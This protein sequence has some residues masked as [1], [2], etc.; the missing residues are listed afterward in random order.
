[1]NNQSS[2]TICFIG[3]GAGARK[4]VYATRGSQCRSRNLNNDARMRILVVGLSVSRMRIPPRPSFLV[5]DA[6][7]SHMPHTYR[8]CACSRHSGRPSTSQRR[9]NTCWRYCPL[10]GGTSRSSDCDCVVGYQCN[11]RGGSWMKL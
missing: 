4:T 7:E 6:L 10:D 5:L 1:M 2:K 11:D 8:R 3:R 9:D